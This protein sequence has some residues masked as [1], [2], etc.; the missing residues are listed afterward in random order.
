ME[1]TQTIGLAEKLQER[2]EQLELQL[3]EY[4]SKQIIE[5]VAGSQLRLE[6]QMLQEEIR[7]IDNK[8]K[9]YVTPL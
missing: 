6:Y 4:P 7:Y 5:K 9:V 1:N 8:L 3:K 2:K